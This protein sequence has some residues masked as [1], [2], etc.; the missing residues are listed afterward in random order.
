MKILIVLLFTLSGI[1]NAN[2]PNVYNNNEEKSEMTSGCWIQLWST[3][4]STIDLWYV[5]KD[6]DRLPGGSTSYTDTKEKLQSLVTKNT[7]SK[8]EFSCEFVSS[9]HG[10]NILLNSMPIVRTEG[11][12]ADWRN[13][14]LDQSSASELFAMLKNDGFCK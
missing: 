6:A 7:C 8:V 9:K 4:P 12:P 1:A 14:L 13:T 5:M 10:A 11:W 3:L 2:S